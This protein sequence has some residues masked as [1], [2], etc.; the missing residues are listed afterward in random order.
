VNLERPENNHHAVIR[1]QRSG[2]VTGINF[3]YLVERG[4]ECNGLIQVRRNAG[5]FVA[6]GEIIAELQSASQADDEALKD[7]HDAW[8]FGTQRTLANDPGYGLRQLV[9][10]ALKALS[11]GVNETTT[12]MMCVNWLGAIL[13]RMSNRCFP[14]QMR[15]SDSHVRVITNQPRLG[16]FIALAFD[17]IRQNAAGNVAILQRQIEVLQILAE[18]PGARVA[19]QPILHQA[20]AVEALMERSV[21]W[22][23]DREPLRAQLKK[24]RGTLGVKSSDENQELQAT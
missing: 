2:Y 24:L 6:E 18:G 20:D 4:D 22:E 10:V 9:D 1:A 21:S 11:P 5:F 16:D 3:N 13:L 14:A 15:T 17:Q 7:I 8:S 12:G 19:R 23:P